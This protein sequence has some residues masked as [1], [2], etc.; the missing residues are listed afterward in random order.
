MTYSNC[1]GA[2]PCWTNASLCSDCN[3]NAEFYTETE[4]QD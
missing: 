1:C 4:N 3:E 2:A